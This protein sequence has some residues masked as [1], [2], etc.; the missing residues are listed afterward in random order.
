MQFYKQSSKCNSFLLLFF[1][2]LQYKLLPKSL[3]GFHYLCLLVL[4]KNLSQ[5][6]CNYYWLAY[7]LS[8]TIES[9]D[10]P[11]LFCFP[12]LLIF[13]FN[14]F[15]IFSQP[16]LYIDNWQSE[17]FLRKKKSAN[18]NLRDHWKIFANISIILFTNLSIDTTKK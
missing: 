13:P 14:K 9:Y 4:H 3:Y 12:F 17:Y 11:R 2:Q 5:N 8:K 18:Y 1:N 15:T 6:L 10:S 16:D 7:L